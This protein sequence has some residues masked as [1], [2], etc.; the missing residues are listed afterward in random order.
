MDKG[1]QEMMTDTPNKGKCIYKTLKVECKQ[2]PTCDGYAKKE[3]EC[4]LAEI[5]NKKL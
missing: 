5:I 1:G 3:K 4:P 2:H